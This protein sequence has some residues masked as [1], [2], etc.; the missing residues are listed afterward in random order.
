[1]STQVRWERRLESGGDSPV[2]ETGSGLGAVR[3]RAMLQLC[4]PRSRTCGKS[5]FMSFCSC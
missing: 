2:G 3:A 1:M 5:R 4:A